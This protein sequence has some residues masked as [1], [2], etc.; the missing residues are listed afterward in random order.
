MIPLRPNAQ[1]ER[2]LR[3]KRDA[4]RAGR[5]RRFLLVKF[6]QFGGTTFEI[7][8]SDYLTG[9]YTGQYAATIAH[10]MPSTI[11]IFEIATRLYENLST[12]D[13]CEPGTATEK[14]GGRPL[15]HWERARQN[16]RELYYPEADSRYFIG[17]AGNRSFGHGMTIN[18]LHLSEAARFPNLDDTLTAA[19]GVP[20]NGEITAES[21]PFGAQGKFYDL[22]Q[23][24]FKGENEWTLLFFRWFQFPLYQLELERGE[25]EQIIAEVATGAHPRYGN[26]EQALSQR[27]AVEG[28]VLTAGQWKWRRWKRGSLADRFFEQYP[29]DFVSC[30]L[31]SGR[32]VFDLMQLMQLAD[33]DVLRKEEHGALWI[34]EDPLP[35]REYVLWADPAEGIERDGAAEDDR[36]DYTAWGIIDR[37]TGEDVAVSLSRIDPAETARQ[38]DRWGRVYNN[39]QAVVERNNHG[40]AVLVLLGDERYGYPNLYEHDDERPGWLTTSANRTPMLDA[41]DLAIREGAYVPIDP[42]MREQM[43]SF[44]ITP[45][46]KAEAAPGKHDDLVTGRAMGNQVRQLPRNYAMSGFA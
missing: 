20:K 1:Q 30:W 37:E 24:A 40:H 11:K 13:L 29:E 32:S 21:T 18:R 4:A 17:T 46:G 43:K 45:K 16:R 12:P 44:I 28:I 36:P 2:I 5:L 38:I 33:G 42:R 34:Y 23:E 25:G 31:A 3:A 22:A 39:A 10:D 6:R 41:L 8:Q 27:L 14:R 7:A 9:T 35:G 26:E 15:F 19:E